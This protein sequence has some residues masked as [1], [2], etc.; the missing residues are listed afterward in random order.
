MI[1]QTDFS[2]NFLIT[3]TWSLFLQDAYNDFLKNYMT[4]EC[5]KEWDQNISSFSLEL[6]IY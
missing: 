4:E 5:A 1:F 3:L 6:N 2:H